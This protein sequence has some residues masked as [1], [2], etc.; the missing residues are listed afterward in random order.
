MLKKIRLAVMFLGVAVL[1]SSCASAG[2]NRAMQAALL[3][4]LKSNKY[5]SAIK[6]VKDKNFYP[7][8]NSQLLKL[9]EKGMVLYL[10][11]NYFQALTTFNEAQKISDDLYTKSISKKIGAAVGSSSSDNYYGTRYE[12]SLIR[13]YQALTNYALYNKGEYESY[14]VMDESGNERQIE[15][16]T[17]DSNSKTDHLRQ[18][19]ANIIEW[20]SLLSSYKAELAGK[21]TF[22]TDLA[23]KMFGAFIHEQYGTKEDEQIAAQ[24]YKDAKTA[25]F[26]NYNLYPSF[27]DKYKDFNK[28]FKKLSTMSENRLSAYVTPTLNAKDLNIFLDSRLSELQSSNKDNVFVVVKDDFVAPKIAKKVVIGFGEKPNDIKPDDIFITVPIEFL[29]SLG[30]PEF[31]QFLFSPLVK[32]GSYALPTIEVEFPYVPQYKS[33]HYSAVLIDANGKETPL[34]IALADPI[35]DFAAN[36]IEL[37]AA[38]ITPIA[39]KAVALHGAALFAAYKIYSEA[40]KSLGDDLKGKL[41]KKAA[42]VAFGVAYK[43]ATVVINKTLQADL[44]YW[45]TLP[46]SI[47]F[48]SAKVPDGAY[49][50]NIFDD[51]NDSP[52][53][54][55]H[56]QKVEVKGNAFADVNINRNVTYEIVPTEQITVAPVSMNALQA[57]EK[58][59]AAEQ[60][61]VGAVVTAP[62]A[63][64]RKLTRAEQ[65]AAAKAEREAEQKAA[66]EAAQRAEQEAAQKKVR[67]AEERAM[68]ERAKLKEELK[69]EI[70]AELNAGK[71]S[72]SGANRKWGF[73][74]Y[75][76]GESE[77]NNLQNDG[78]VGAKAVLN[79]VNIFYE[80]FEEDYR[81]SKAGYE[82][83]VDLNGYSIGAALYIPLIKTS[84]VRISPGLGAQLTQY[85]YKSRY[86][87]SYYDYYGNNYS[88]QKN[89]SDGSET[90][91][92][93]F[94]GINLR[95]PIYKALHF[96]L[97]VTGVVIATKDEIYLK[98]NKRSDDS[99]D[100]TNDSYVTIDHTGLLKLDGGL[101]LLF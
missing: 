76:G 9:L 64:P 42:L 58:A 43:G 10:S 55:V 30:G 59:G 27:N 92:D 38:S 69:D 32:I 21:V 15:A 11:G 66:R 44:R 80:T 35:S 82:P 86:R 20:D 36:E 101:L 67:E 6:Q 14:A 34:E 53:V 28:D 41:A 62:P 45:S 56:T 37:D 90:I 74:V 93:G 29:L 52:K 88:E 79:W 84:F 61:S 39:I 49:T 13:F 81:D 94:L 85:N 25:A 91:I 89:G 12:R 100:I 73:G 22:K 98:R 63:A 54:L 33:K 60:T 1:I 75:G 4:D 70:L 72:K 51:T 57:A 68:Q 99:H 2:K 50:L 17:L 3:N 40:T 19:R 65:E 24:L 48:A 16:K 87:V 95:F 78:Y 5:E 96:D 71:K 23:Q 46:N 77:G 47:R 18:A 83:N 97:T 26:Q 31:Q 7:D 8:E